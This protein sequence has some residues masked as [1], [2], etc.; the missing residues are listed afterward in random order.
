[1]P[2]LTR[3]FSVPKPIEAAYQ[4]LATVQ[5]IPEYTQVPGING[6]SPAPLAAGARWKNRGAT[7]KM[8]SWDT[9]TVKEV[10]RGRIAWHTR[11]MVLGIIPVGADWSYTLETPAGGGPTTTITNTFEAVTMF[12][13]PVG[14]MIKAPFLPMVYL[15]RGTMMASEAKLR[16]A[17][18]AT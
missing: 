17:L 2:V 16:K 15:A 5:R 13:L 4:F 6:G 18:G 8:P 11:S 1:M 12:G 9:T 10:T 14:A 7:L 3:Q